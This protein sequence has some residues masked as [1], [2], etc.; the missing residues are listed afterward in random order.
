MKGRNR[1]IFCEAQMI[2]AVQ[3]YFNEHLLKDKCNKVTGVRQMTGI[4][5]VG[6]EIYVEELKEMNII[7]EFESNYYL[8]GG[9]RTQ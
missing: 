8:S 4:S 1:F 3:H 9:E 7:V 6:F 2:E 5:E